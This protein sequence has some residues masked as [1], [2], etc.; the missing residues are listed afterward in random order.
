VLP[1]PDRPGHPRRRGRPHLG[2]RLT[3]RFPWA[4]WNGVAA[5]SVRRRPHGLQRSRDR[6]VPAPRTT[7]RQ[8]RPDETV[9]S[10][11]AGPLPSTTRSPVSHRVS[12]RDRAAATAPGGRA[13][14]APPTPA[15][16]LCAV[17]LF[18]E[19]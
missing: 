6:R 14:Q 18:D 7:R 15:A 2:P 12:P 4:A 8:R 11:C 3:A 19:G 13:E 17:V 9:F 10:R 5:L 1:R 16:S